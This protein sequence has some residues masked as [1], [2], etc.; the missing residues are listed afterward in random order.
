[1]QSEEAELDFFPPERMEAKQV[2]MKLQYGAIYLLV[3]MPATV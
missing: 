1:M 3:E 2:S